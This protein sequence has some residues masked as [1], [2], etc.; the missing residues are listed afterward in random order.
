MSEEFEAGYLTLY[1]EESMATTD[2]ILLMLI[3]LFDIFSRSQEL[4][5]IILTSYVF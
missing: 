4:F 1:S 2:P 5:R 3:H